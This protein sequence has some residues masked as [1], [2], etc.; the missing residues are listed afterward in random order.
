MA[1]ILTFLGKG[2]V[3]STTMAIAS[4]HSYTQQGKKVLLAVQ[5]SSPCFSA[6]LGKDVGK[7]VTEIVPNL[8]AIRLHSSKLLEDS[9]EKVE[10]LEK[11]YLRSPILKIFMV[12]N[13]V[14]YPAWMKP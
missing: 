4:A 2:G 8:N 12:Q 6:L 3:G 11:K 9:W 10:E 14:Y 1:F 13:L 5:D 7:E